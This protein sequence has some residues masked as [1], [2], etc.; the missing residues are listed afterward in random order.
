MDS[1]N[2]QSSIN[3]LQEQ[4]RSLTEE[5]VQLRERNEVLFS[6]LDSA[7]NKLG[8]QAASKSDLSVKLVQCEEDKLKI[9]KD[10]VDV[11]IEA[12]KMR[13]QYEAEIF[14]LKNMV[15][16]QEGT[17]SS[18]QT[19]CDRLRQE[20]SAASAHLEVI[21][22][23]ERDLAEEYGMLKSNFLSLSGAYERERTHSEELSAELLALAHTHDTLLQERERTHRHML[24][25]ERVRA[26]LSR[27]SHNR[28]RPEEL[29]QSKSQLERNG[30]QNNLRD[31]LDKLRKSYEGHQRQ[32]EEKVVA[33]GREQQENKRAIQNTRHEL[34]QQS[35]T[36]ITSQHQLKEAEAEFSKLQNHLKELNREYRARLTRYIQDVTECVTAAGDGDLGQKLKGF[37]ESMLEEVKTSHRSREEQLT[38]AVRTYRKRVQGLSNTYQQLLIAYR[39]QREQILALPEHALEAGPPEAHFSPAG[40]E[41]RG[42]T[43]RELHRLREDKARLESQLKLAREQMAVSTESSQRV[44]LTQDAWNDVQKQIRKITNTT[45]EAQER[46]RSQLITRATVAEEQVSELKEYVDNHLGRYKLEIMRLR[47]LLGSQEG[48]SNSARTHKPRPLHKSLKSSSYEI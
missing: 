22:R 26:L 11:Q 32:L 41:L 29:E 20:V 14:K 21:E 37:V 24:E 17:V 18:L 23:S 13:E 3:Q 9:S 28:V 48:R 45:Q 12:N 25:V 7:Q 31:E 40:T 4:I 19:E 10:L 43:E 36:L 27:T 46:E 33:M 30:V 42:E 8:Q 35:A 34:S 44:G 38:K 1:T 16:S 6:K 2:K 39:L 15:L 47:R 5:N